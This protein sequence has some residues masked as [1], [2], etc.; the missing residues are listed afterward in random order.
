MSN[1]VC[2]EIANVEKKC[3]TFIGTS[4]SNRTNI[5][6]GECLPKLNAFWLLYSNKL[7]GEQ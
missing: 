3:Q 2:D 7:F 5:V 1:I 4:F 6:E